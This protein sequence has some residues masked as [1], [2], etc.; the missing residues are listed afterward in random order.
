MAQDLFYLKQATSV[1]G[2][3]P[4]GKMIIIALALL[5]LFIPYKKWQPQKKYAPVLL[6]VACAVYLYGNSLSVFEK[7]NSALAK[8]EIGFNYFS[9]RDNIKQNGIFIHL[10]QTLAINTKPKAG[11][12]QFFANMKPNPKNLVPALEGYDIFIIACESC[13]F[14]N[15]PAS[16][17]HN[18][19]ARLLS[20]GHKFSHLV[21]PVYGGNTAEAEFEAITG[22]PANGLPGVK[23]QIY[24]SGFPPKETLPILLKKNQYRSYYYHNGIPSSWNREEALP[25]LGFEQ[26][27]FYDDMTKEKTT[28]AR[29][30]VA[31]NKI[32]ELYAIEAKSPAPIYNQIMTFYTHGPYHDEQGDG[33]I[34]SYNKKV[35]L[36]VD[37]YLDFEKSLSIIAKQN[38]RKIAIFIFGDHKPSLN[39]V[40]YKNDTFPKNF[41]SDG[42]EASTNDDFHLRADFSSEDLTHVDKVSLFFKLI[43]EK[44]PDFPAAFANK[45]IYC[46]PAMIANST[47][48]KTSKY[49]TQLF[50]LCAE[51]SSVA[52]SDP[53]WQR[54][55]FPEAVYSDFLF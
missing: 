42:D 49:Y 21:S 26:D 13:Y 41:F 36:V 33:G 35:K 37:D 46:L 52:L 39:E 32:L 9:P 1:H 25:K 7:V 38:N 45:P 31:Y 29:D 6:G 48:M 11:P 2:F 54:Q 10:I 43:N 47:G 18:D 16:L 24:G 51:N 15:K 22:F 12:H 23:F 20:N 50:N 28:W 53:N 3:M 5:S 4:V 44:T 17:L 34:S 19:F 40:F 30:S 8:I 27:F 14:E 55:T